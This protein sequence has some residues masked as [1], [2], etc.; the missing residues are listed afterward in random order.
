MKLHSIP[1]KIE[2]FTTNHCREGFDS[3]N[4]ELNRYFFQQ[5]S[6]DVKRHIAAVFVLTTENGQIIGYYTLSSLA[7]DVGELPE[8]ISKKLPKYHFLPATLLGRL[9]V[10]RSYQKKGFGRL[11]LM[12]ALCRSVKTS[13]EVASMAIVVNAKTD[14]V[15]AFYEQYGFIM[16]AAPIIKL[17][18]PMK[19]AEKIFG[20]YC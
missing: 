12:D 8:S 6:Q 1:Y 9:A 11:L 16:L 18:L 10:D 20:L 17:F 14:T 3:G 19:T 13:K 4:G 5:A 2:I 7:V 15:A